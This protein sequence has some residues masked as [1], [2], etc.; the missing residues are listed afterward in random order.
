MC[1]IEERTGKVTGAPESLTTPSPYAQHLSFS[2]DGRRAVYVS[3]VGSKNILKAGFNPDLAELTG[4]PV[5]ITQGFKYTSQPNL[6]PDGEWY[7][8]STQGE[9]AGGPIIIDKGRN[10]PPRQLPTT[11]SKIATRAGRLTEIAS[12]FTQTAAA[13]TK[14]G[15]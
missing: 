10:G 1:P 7:V 4:Q 3:Q 11:T 5:A 12:S 2:R 13:G 9:K 8:Y 15:Q 14:H 6:S